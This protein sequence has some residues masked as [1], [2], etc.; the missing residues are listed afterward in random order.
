MDKEPDPKKI[1]ELGQGAEGLEELYEHDRARYSAPVAEA[2]LG[3]AGRMITASKSL[4]AS[5][6]PNNVPVFN[7]NVCTQRRGK[8][9][10]GGLDLTK[11]E[12]S[13]RQLAEELAESTYVLFERAARFGNETTPE[14]RNFVLRLDPDGAAAHA[15]GSSEVR[16]AGCIRSLAEDEAPR[17]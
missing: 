1:F 13:L 5:A 8:I 10:F 11:D 2:I 7:A 15:R 17:L 6:H 12:P 9:W 16:T 3:P 14:F 4:Y